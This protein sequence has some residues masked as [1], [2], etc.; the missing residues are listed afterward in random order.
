MKQRNIIAAVFLVVIGLG[1]AYMTA[2]LETR[3]IKDFSE[4]SFFP[5]I[6]TTIF[7]VLSVS[8]LA[9][10]LLS[11]HN[12]ADSSLWDSPGRA[13]FALISF[14]IYLLVLPVLGFLVP[15]IPFFGLLMWLYGERRIPFIVIGAVGIP[16][17]LFF[18]FRNI[19]RIILPSGVLESLF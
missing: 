12:G 17:M 5:W 14:L 1:Y 19:F 9:Q 7:L 18:L 8:L 11:E 3:E 2:N 16:V 10:G 6:I 4:P 15:S 13:V